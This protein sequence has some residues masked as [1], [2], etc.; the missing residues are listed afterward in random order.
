MG[1]AESPGTLMLMPI[2]DQLALVIT[3]FGAKPLYMLLSLVLTGWLWRSSSRD[4]VLIRRSLMAFFLGETFCAINFVFFGGLSLALEVTHSAGMV[5]MNAWLPWGLFIL[6]D[7]RVLRLTAV[8]VPCVG[9]RFCS[10]C[11]KKEGGNCGIH[12]LFLF[13]APAMA[14]LALMPLTAPLAPLD[15]VM[16][17]FS[18]DVSQR[19]D[20]VQQILEWR[21]FPITACLLLIATFFILLR[22]QAGIHLA[23]APF[24]WG[25]AFFVFSF[26]R[27]VLQQSF[28]SS[29][30]WINS[31]EEITEFIVIAGVGLLLFV[32]RRQLAL[33]W[34]R[35]APVTHFEEEA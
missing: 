2:L 18:T 16:K 28:R 1:G 24:F 7:T 21:V 5:V 17:C 3:A 6:L 30:A 8:E 23:Q 26:M 14:L 10:S 22:G 12:K 27:F 13:A 32:F 15:I 25:V 34:W 9:V 29:P 33:P 11:W 20:R 31:W 4:L 19:I 35:Q